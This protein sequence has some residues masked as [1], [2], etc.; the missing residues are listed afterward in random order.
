[1]NVTDV[2]ELD[3]LQWE[4]SWDAYFF[5]IERK[6]LCLI[7]VLDRVLVCLVLRVLGEYEASYYFQELREENNS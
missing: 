5:S 1:V 7:Y 4:I 6:S 2:T 3:T